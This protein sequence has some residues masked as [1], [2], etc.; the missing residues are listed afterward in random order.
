MLYDNS[1]MEETTTSVK[2]DSRR[3]RSTTT[4]VPSHQRTVAQQRR[5]LENVEFDKLSAE[6]PIARA[7]SGQHIDKT[8]VVRLASTFIR[9]HEC[10]SGVNAS[11][12]C[13]GT[14]ITPST[15]DTSMLDEIPGL[16]GRK[17]EIPGCKTFP[18]HK[19]VPQI[20]DGFLACLS[21]NF[22]LLYVSETISIHLGLSQVEMIGNSLFEY[23][24]REDITN[25]QTMTNTL[26]HLD[27]T[28]IVNVRMKSTLAKRANKDT[29]R[30]T[31][32]YKVIRM[33]MNVIRRGT[34]HCFV[35]FCEPLPMLL[36]SSIR[37]DPYSFAITADVDL[38]I[39]YVDAR[40]QCLITNCRCEEILRSANSNC[41]IALKGSN[42]YHLVH[43][44]DLTIVSKMH[45]E[46]L[47]LGASK[48]QLYRLIKS[49]CSSTV[50]VE[51]RQYYRV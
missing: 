34:Y 16:P 50:Y 46:V 40:Q 15:W 36:V 42:F 9:L 12:G 1:D 39:C 43:H 10:I 5:F 21:F 11:V 22:D 2:S 45:F 49:D 28:V 47:Q 24:H 4:P 17:L 27:E 7:I 14:R 23:V 8:S 51:D 37:L 13:Y 20:L 35:A 41:I 29:M 33:E 25:L 30:Y 18:L 3:R 48:T 6:L 38:A 44:E 31:A 26:V 19:A 32:G